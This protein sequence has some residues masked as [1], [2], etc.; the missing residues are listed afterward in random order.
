MRTL[1]GSYSWAKRDGGG[2]NLRAAI[3]AA[4]GALKRARGQNCPPYLVLVY[5]E[6]AVNSYVIQDLKITARPANLDPLGSR[7]L[8]HA[9]VRGAIAR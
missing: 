2:S 9:E 4:L 7:V 1:N 3:Q 6:D 8:A 5:R